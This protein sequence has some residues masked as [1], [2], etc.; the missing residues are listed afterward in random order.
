[1]KLVYCYVRHR[2]F[3]LE[4][5]HTDGHYTLIKELVRRGIIPGAR[6]IME[7][8]NQRFTPQIIEQDDNFTVETIGVF[9]KLKID[10]GDI[11]W[12]RGGWKPWIPRIE[13]W[14]ENHWFMYYGANAGHHSWPWWDVILWDLAE[15]NK[16]GKDDKL[17]WHYRKMVSPE[18]HYQPMEERYDICVG[19]S[20]IYD[21]KGQY[22]ILPI[23]KKYKEL[24]GK[25]LRVCMPGSFYSHERK[26]EAMRKEIQEGKWPN[27]HM[28]GWLTRTQLVEAY[29]RSK[30]FYAATCGGQ[31]DRCLPEA[32][33][34]GCRSIIALS[35]NHP[36]YA[37]ADP[38]MSFVQPDQDDLE[39]VAQLLA[40][41]G[42]YASRREIADYFQ[43]E[44][45]LETAI[46]YLRPVLDHMMANK[47]DRS[48]L[49]KLI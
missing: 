42:D 3:S 19:A 5:L 22:R 7:N 40:G 9:H 48:S 4:Q 10:P 8:Y 38:R 39:S 18:F 47:K 41:S 44:A 35:K 45:G 33:M 26:T 24:T 37:Y 6:I 31:G 15:G 25:D 14:A 11:V 1:M 12:I 2:N 43:A 30:W 23:C 46:A 21:R 20:H 28:P 17:W 36:P 16:I 32:G 29:C 13:E 27:I 49:R 34:C